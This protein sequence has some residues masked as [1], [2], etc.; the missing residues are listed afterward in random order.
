MVVPIYTSTCS[1]GHLLAAFRLF[2]LVRLLS[3][4]GLNLH[5]GLNFQ[6]SDYQ[7]AAISTFFFCEV[8]AENLLSIFCLFVYST[9][10]YIIS[11]VLDFPV[12]FLFE[13]C[14]FS[15]QTL[16]CLENTMLPHP[17][18]IWKTSWTDP[19]VFPDHVPCFYFGKYD[20]H[21]H[22]PDHFDI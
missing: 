8:P 3:G 16:K 14:H 12:L 2:K 7:W 11:R 21:T 9:T 6:S 5:C 20:C 17:K 15:S 13:I 22:I 10:G 1:V 18:H 4:W 19:T